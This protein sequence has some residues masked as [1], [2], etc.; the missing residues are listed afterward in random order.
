VRAIFQDLSLEFPPGSDFDLSNSGYFLLGQVVENV[1]KQPFADYLQQNVLAPAGMRHSGIGLAV[2]AIGHEFD[3]A[4]V[5]VPARQRHYTSYGA[6]AGMVSTAA[7]LARWDRA[8]RTPGLVLSQASLDRMTTV[9]RDDYGLGWFLRSEP[10]RTIAWHPGGVEGYNATIARYLDDGVTVY[11]LANTEAVDTRTV[12]YDIGQIAHGMTVTPPP[13]HL[14]T[15]LSL[16]QLSRYTGRYVLSETSHKELGGLI[17][18][19]ELEAIE[20]VN[21]E[22]QGGRLYMQ[23]PE[24]AAKWMHFVGDDR[25]FFKDPSGTTAEFGPPGAPVT[26]LTLQQG[27]LRFVLRRDGI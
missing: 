10:G 19:V 2:D 3:E 21:V 15:T 9:V 1:S 7:D 16:G 4:E 12:V 26:R 23:V 24:H 13:E 14:E 17:D 11:A 20:K 27:E 25:F 22:I 6:A 5:L 8:L 18:P